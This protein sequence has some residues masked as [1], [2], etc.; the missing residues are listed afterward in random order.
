MAGLI[1]LHL[2]S[3]DQSEER[4]WIHHRDRDAVPKAD[5]RSRAHEILGRRARVPM[6]LM[7][8]HLVLEPPAPLDRFPPPV[9]LDALP[10]SDS[11][12]PGTSPVCDNRPAQSASAHRS[13]SGKSQEDLREICS[14]SPRFFPSLVLHS[15][16]ITARDGKSTSFRS[17]EVTHVG[18]DDSRVS[19]LF[20][21]RRC[22]P[23]SLDAVT[24]QCKEHRI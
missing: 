3:G 11:Q 16:Y 6:S 14:P 2:L 23:V 10:V 18:R 20:H 21:Q 7:I 1:L 24:A 5:M 15:E 19:H 9:V 4:A 8:F 12:R 17:Q 13:I 22:H